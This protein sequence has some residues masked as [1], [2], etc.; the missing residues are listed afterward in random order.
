MANETIK[1][2]EC[3]ARHIVTDAHYKDLKNDI[4]D[5]KDDLKRV[6]VGICGDVEGKSPGILQ[7]LQAVEL[8]FKILIAV[9]SSSVFL[10]LVGG[11][12]KVVFFK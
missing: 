9:L 10:A 12:V 6:I 7:R 11:A 1:R 2:D 8:R 3:E 4:G 5:I